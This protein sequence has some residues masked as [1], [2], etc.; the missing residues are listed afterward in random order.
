MNHQLADLYVVPL[1][2]RPKSCALDAPS[3]SGDNQA[4]S[5]SRCA[6]SPGEICHRH[7]DGT[8]ALINAATIEYLVRSIA[9]QE[10]R[11]VDD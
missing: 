3:L 7:D 9:A 6:P 2:Q 8:I 11:K 10:N 5:W 1:I 4:I